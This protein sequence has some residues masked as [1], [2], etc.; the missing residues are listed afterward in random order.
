MTKGILTSD[1]CFITV[2]NKVY[3]DVCGRILILNGSNL[4]LGTELG[5]VV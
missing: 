5:I 4:I 1:G 3:F 2:V